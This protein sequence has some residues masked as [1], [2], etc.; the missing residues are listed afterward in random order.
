MPLSSDSSFLSL[1]RRDFLKKSAVGAGVF[2]LP[3]LLPASRTEAVKRQMLAQK[4]AHQVFDERVFHDPTNETTIHTWWHWMDNAITREGIDRD[5]RSIA[6]QNISEVTLFNVT[7]FNEQDFGIPPVKFNSDEWYELFRYALDRAKVYGLK[8]GVHNCDGW[9]TSGGPWN[10]PEQSMKMCTWNISLIEGDQEIETKLPIPFSNRGY[11]EDV[12]IYAYQLPG[13]REQLR[14]DAVYRH[15]GENIGSVLRDGYPFGQGISVAEGDVLEVSYKDPIA[16]EIVQLFPVYAFGEDYP[17]DDQD[18]EICVF[19]SQDGSTFEKKGCFRQ[20]ISDE[21]NELSFRTDKV[22]HIRFEFRKLIEHEEGTPFLINHLEILQNGEIPLYFP[23]LSHHIDK[24]VAREHVVSQNALSHQNQSDFTPI[25]QSDIL[26]LT[27]RLQ[28]DGRFTWSA[29]EGTWRVVRFGF[30]TTNTVN[31]PASKA[32]TGLECD[33]MDKA[34][35]EHHF[36]QFPQK[37]IDHAGDHV[38]DTFRFLFVDS[39]ECKFQNWTKAL[40]EEFEKRRGYSLTPWIPVICGNVVHSNHQTESFLQ[41]YRTTL[42]ELVEENYFHHYQVLCERAGLKFYAEAPYHSHHYPPLDILRTN[43]LFDTSMV[44]FWAYDWNRGSLDYQSRSYVRVSETAHSANLYGRSVVPA[45]AFTGYSDFSETPWDMKLFG[46]AAICAGGTNQMVLHTHV[47]QPL[48]KDLIFT[49]GPFGQN[50]NRTMPWWEKSSVWFDYLKRQ[51]YMLQKGI[52]VADFLYYAGDEAYDHEMPE[53]LHLATREYG[54]QM[55]NTDALMRSDLANGEISMINGL[56]YKLLILPEVPRMDL[57]VLEKIEELV[58][59]GAVVYGPRPTQTVSHL[60]SESNDRKLATIGTRL[61]GAIDGKSVTQN[62]YKKGLVIYGS[63]IGKVVEELGLQPDF[64]T[65]NPD[66]PILL[67][68]HRRFGENDLYFLVNQEDRDVHLQCRFNIAGKQPEIWDP[69][70]GTTR[71]TAVFDEVNGLTHLPI[72]LRP[73]E[74]QFV[75]FRKPRRTD[76]IKQV[77]IG[78]EHHF[79]GTSKESI[80]EAEYDQEGIVIRGTVSN[81]YRL[82]KT[83][84]ETAEIKTSAPETSELEISDGEVEFFGFNEKPFSERTSELKSFSK[85]RDSRIRYFS[86][87]AIYHLSFK[88]PATFLNPA[89]GEVYLRFSDTRVIYEAKL[90]G[91]VIGSS[92]FPEAR[93]PTKGLLKT[94]NELEVAVYTTLRNRIIEDMKEY[95]ELRSIQTTAP[96]WVMPNA[97]SELELCGINAPIVLEKPIT[98]WM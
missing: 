2:V 75:L 27:D 89:D 98:T 58:S 20:L 14:N 10:S 24:V 30:T 12:S 28:S 97:E 36:S 51:Q 23:G 84:G 8:I 80:P 16:V 68:T 17:P 93:F 29:P 95:G 18:L 79:P 59:Q 55:C 87:K 13:V 35:L 82:K 46:E 39:W 19:T 15:N 22:R 47:H 26:D 63:P 86:G 65:A 21:I 96:Q 85:S 32:G 72:T 71:E 38:G 44:E 50:F 92:C 1:K 74:A 9:S 76:R 33:K 78:S 7:M 77:W 45:E 70:T 34:A 64:S 90:N 54:I 67:H 48:E 5:L 4:N 49:L 69:A 83:N 53:E 81:N 25:E 52:R 11:Y 37:L 31:A 62:H 94:K 42:A 73:R 6:D 56:S 57:P 43:S 3:G 41:D 60:N 88:A 91:I 40:P 61:W 66:D